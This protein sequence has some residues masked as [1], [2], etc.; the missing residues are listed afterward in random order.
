M[1][2]GQGQVAYEEVAF[3]IFEGAARGLVPEAGTLAV[4]GELA[5]DLDDVNAPAGG[6]LFAFVQAILPR[7]VQV[8]LE[9]LSHWRSTMRL[10]C[11]S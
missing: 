8:W 9:V 11:W 4:E 6:A 3:V 5:V 7:L 10:T 2:L 1:V